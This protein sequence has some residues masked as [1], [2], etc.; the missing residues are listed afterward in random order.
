MS[1]DKDDPRQKEVNG[2]ILCADW[3]GGYSRK[4]EKEMFFS[5]SDVGSD[6]DMRGT[7]VFAFVPYSAGTSRYDDF[8][9]SFPVL[10]RKE[11]ADHDMMSKLPMRWLG[12][13]ERGALAFI[14]HVDTNWAFPITATRTRDAERR[15]APGLFSQ[16]LRQLMNGYTVGLAMDNFR[17]RFA[18]NATLLLSQ[19]TT[20]KPSDESRWLVSEKLATVDIRNYVVIGDPAVSTPARRAELQ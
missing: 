20:Q 13:P 3:P 7:I 2:A 8:A 5:A 15:P 10:T 17:R 4:M 19:L 11:I 1:F 14:G 9:M 16:M 6:M 12:T 18:L